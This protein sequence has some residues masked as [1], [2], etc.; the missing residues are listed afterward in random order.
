MDAVKKSLRVFLAGLCAFLAEA[1]SA[2][3]KYR[4][5]LFFIILD[6]NKSPGISRFP[7]RKWR[8]CILP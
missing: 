5:G 3:L 8:L 1:K 4:A 2:L 7:W 6:I